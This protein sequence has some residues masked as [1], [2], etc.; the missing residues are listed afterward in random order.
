MEGDGEANISLTKIPPL[1]LPS[2]KSINSSRY[3][4]VSRE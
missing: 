2:L 1:I 3:S 4:A